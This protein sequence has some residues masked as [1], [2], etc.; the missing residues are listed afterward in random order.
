M[1]S[2]ALYLALKA[3]HLAAVFAWISGTLLVARALQFKPATATLEPTARRFLISVARWDRTVTS[4]ALVLAW[5]LGMTL[6][7]LGGWLPPAPWIMIKVIFAIALAGLHGYLAGRL[8][9][10]I[11]GTETAA[12]AWLSAV[13]LLLATGAISLAITKPL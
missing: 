8:R 5:I 6:L 3:V 11:S 9:K 1:S 7:K 4:P 10:T 2:G 13:I 12:A